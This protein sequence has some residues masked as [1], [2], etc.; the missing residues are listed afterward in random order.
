MS[1]YQA[2]VRAKG[3]DATGM[4]EQ[5]ARELH[6]NL[7]TY[8][9]AIVE[10]RADKRSDDSD[11]VHGVELV[12][13]Q[14]EPAVD[15]RLDDHLRE[16]TKALH[17][18]RVLHSDD[19]QLSIDSADDIAPK[20]TDVIDAGVALIDD[21]EAVQEER[22]EDAQHAYVRNPATELCECGVGQGET[23]HAIED[24]EPVKA[25][26]GQKAAAASPF[27]VVQ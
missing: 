13:T 3:L 6:T 26:R 27:S 11:G 25:K 17:T 20:V 10:V 9:M 18:N 14:F 1:D 19:E 12:I 21:V 5:I 23:V 22:W 24:A 15:Q 4:T 16:L 2:K 8:Q 7:G